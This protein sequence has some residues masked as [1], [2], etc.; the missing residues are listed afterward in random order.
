MDLSVSSTNQQALSSTN[1]HALL[2]TNQNSFLLFE[3]SPHRGL[4]HSPLYSVSLSLLRPGYGFSLQPS[5]HI[6]FL[7]GRENSQSHNYHK[8][9]SIS[10][11]I[12]PVG[13]TGANEGRREDIHIW[14]GGLTPLHNSLLLLLHPPGVQT[15]TV[16]GR[17][18]GG[19]GGLE[20]LLRVNLTP[21][22]GGQIS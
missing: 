20:H 9:L 8:E 16:C 15:Y 7:S 11:S 22:L 18:K 6:G 12:N 19:E 13:G 3:G 4:F 21:V 1:Q 2:S 14:E 5:C 17:G 10:P